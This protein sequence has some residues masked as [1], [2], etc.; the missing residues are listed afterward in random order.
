MPLLELSR[1]VQVWSYTVSH[2]QL[3][4]RAAKDGEHPTRVD[5]LFKGVGAMSLPTV[6]PDA[7]I[8]EAEPDERASILAS[9]SIDM[10]EE[11]RCYVLEGAGFSGWV[12]AGVVVFVEDEGDYFDTSPLLEP[13]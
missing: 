4:L 5:V 10:P 9:T 8:R 3:L 6:M 11:R 2:S 1:M 7:S 13:K 12:L